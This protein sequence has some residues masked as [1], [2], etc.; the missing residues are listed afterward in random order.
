MAPEAFI[1]RLLSESWHFSFSVAIAWAS[2]YVY[3]RRDFERSVEVDLIV[4]L[5]FQGL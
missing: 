1:L 3:M 4:R 5:G 2:S